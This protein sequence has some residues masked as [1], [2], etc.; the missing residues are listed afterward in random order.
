MVNRSGRETESPKS[1]DDE[2]RLSRRAVLF[3][4]GALA[5]AAAARPFLA[6]AAGSATHDDEPTS[7]A[8][9]KVPEL[10]HRI[11]RTNGIRM[12]VVE[13][14]SGPLVILLHGFPECWYS[15]R[16]QL[17]ML[18]QAG[19]RAVAPDL[20]GYG[21]SDCPPDGGKY[22]I[23]DYIG[24][25][26]G[27]IGTLGVEQ[28]V[29]AGHDFGAT[30]AWQ[31]ALMR[32]DMFRAVIGLSAPFRPRGFGTSALP[33]TLMPQNDKAVYYQLY[34]ATPQ[35]ETGME[36]NKR[37]TLRS[38]FYQM[39]GE[40]LQA[41]SPTSA[42][43]GPGMIP[44]SGAALPENPPLP[45]WITS[46]ALEVYI[47]EF[48]RS[49]F[50]GPLSWYRNIDRSWELLGITQGAEVT[51]PALY[52]TGDR[53][54]VAAANREFIPLQAKFVPKL[55]RSLILPGCGHWTQQERA[56]DVSAAMI[57][58]LQQL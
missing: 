8:D 11:V 35:A 24:D 17:T 3:G 54:F 43:L 50:R 44:R 58:F 52:V 36:Q 9:P 53:D 23:L 4:T 40:A 27:L 12:H 28:A 5:S 7:W 42:D 41:A 30:I 48:T 21:R 26:V 1:N 32:P 46:A 33:T 6:L 47:E 38:L 25:I 19:F 29:I 51:V 16:H 56:T 39:S 55:R 37:Q 31:A 45:G 57:D 10:T 15:W 2:A 22:T 18:A 20:R 14:G 34:L 13:R 49:G